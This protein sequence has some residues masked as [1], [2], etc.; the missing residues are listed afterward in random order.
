MTPTGTEPSAPEGNATTTAQQKTHA[1][2][3]RV[4]LSGR[5]KQHQQRCY[6]PCDIFTSFAC[7]GACCSSRRHRAFV[8]QPVPMSEDRPDAPGRARLAHEARGCGRDAARDRDRRLRTRR[9]LTRGGAQKE[10][11]AGGEASGSN[12]SLGQTAAARLRR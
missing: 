3:A 8:H 1:R 10:K 5:L 12:L 4:A 7:C 9:A 11:P 2:I 6:I